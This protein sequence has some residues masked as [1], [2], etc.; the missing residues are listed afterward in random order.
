MSA[1]QSLLFTRVA[2][3]ITIGVTHHVI[4]Q[5]VASCYALGRRTASGVIFQPM[6]DGDLPPL[7]R[8]VA[9]AA[10]AGGVTALQA[11]FGA[12]PRCAAAPIACARFAIGLTGRP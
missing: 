5:P 1:R 10:S 3:P 8:I 2:Q 9:I 6:A 4:E 11:F 7:H 12:T